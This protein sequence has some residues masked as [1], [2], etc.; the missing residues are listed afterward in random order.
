MYT[1]KNY[2]HI[3]IWSAKGNKFGS[4]WDGMNL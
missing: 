1:L 2:H 3:K 4:N